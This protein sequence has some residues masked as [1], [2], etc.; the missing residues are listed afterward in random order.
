[1]ESSS[2]V[3]LEGDSVLALYA[4]LSRK[5]Y[6]WDEVAVANYFLTRLE[7]AIKEGEKQESNSTKHSDGDSSG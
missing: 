5:S 2:T 7:N 4:L 1:M 3:I 6:T